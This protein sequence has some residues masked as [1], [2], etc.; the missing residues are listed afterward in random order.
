MPAPAP[1][2]TDL[3][4]TAI[5]SYTERDLLISKSVGRDARAV[6]SMASPLWHK[7][8]GAVVAMSA[9]PPQTVPSSVLPRL[10]STRIERRVISFLLCRVVGEPGEPK[11]IWPAGA[12]RAPICPFRGLPINVG[13]WLALG[14]SFISREPLHHAGWTTGRHRLSSDDKQRTEKPADRA[15][16]AWR[17]PCNA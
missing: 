7:V 1:S 14:P 16:P 3:P 10:R 8:D 4:L 5:R 17:I 2:P 6:Y 12:S 15:Y 13:A 11:L 9:T